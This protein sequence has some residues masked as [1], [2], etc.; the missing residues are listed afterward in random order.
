[1][2]CPKSP[3]STLQTRKIAKRR[4]NYIK[5][6]PDDRAAVLQAKNQ[7]LS[8]RAIAESLK[9][10]RST[11]R[12][13]EKGKC[14]N[15]KSFKMQAIV[16]TA[17]RKLE[18]LGKKRKTTT[19]RRKITSAEVLRHL[20][21][22]LKEYKIAKEDIPSAR[23]LRRMLANVPTPRIRTTHF[24]PNTGI[25]EEQEKRRELCARFY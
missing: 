22:N 13:L 20:N 9:M 12:N 14:G 23:T 17:C 25:T 4:Q 18:G 6:T 16:N 8:Q 7:K 1:M 21:D 2:T 3:C 15:E 19:S 5:R 24:I 10:S 11:M